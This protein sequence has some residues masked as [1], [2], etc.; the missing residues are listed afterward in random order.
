MK[1]CIKMKRS[2]IITE[3][4][5]LVDQSRNEYVISSQAVEYENKRQQDLLHDIEF[6]TNNRERAKLCTKLHKCRISRR[7]HKDIEEES[8]IITDFFADPQHGKTIDKMKQMLGALRKIEKYHENRTYTRR[9][10]DD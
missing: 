6:T 9:V 1:R 10:Q 5:N 3:F 8:K 7:V 2:E 4:L